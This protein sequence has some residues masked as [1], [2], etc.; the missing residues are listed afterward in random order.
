MGY[1]SQLVRPSELGSSSVAVAVGGVECYHV[2]HW[3]LGRCASGDDEC[4]RV[5]RRERRLILASGHLV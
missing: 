1:N 2:T 4:S 3:S 5:G